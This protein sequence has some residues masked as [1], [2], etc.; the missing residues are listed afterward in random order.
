MVQIFLKLK[1]KKHYFWPLELV[2]LQLQILKLVIY[3]FQ[4]LKLARKAVFV[5]TNL[6]F[7]KKNYLWFM[8]LVNI[9]SDSQKTKISPLYLLIQIFF[10]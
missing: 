10:L 2:K 8:Q 7:S 3:G 5:F 1:V 9:I 6:K 4:V